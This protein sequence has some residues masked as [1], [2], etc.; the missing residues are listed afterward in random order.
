MPP[1]AVAA[2]P[3]QPP[4]VAAP[5]AVLQPLLSRGDAVLALGDITSARLFY[6]RAAGLG[7]AQGA[8]SLGKTYDPAF[9]ASIEAT[10]VAPDR[11][12]AALWYRKA[13]KL[14]D[15]EATRRLRLL[16]AGR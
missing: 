9:L 5:P 1:A 14:G 10:G 11:S 12:V 2:T 8:T 7:S 6:E 16:S 15:A 4:P 3:A 13:A